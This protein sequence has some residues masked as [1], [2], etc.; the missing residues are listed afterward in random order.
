MKQKLELL[1]NISIVVLCLTVSGILIEKHFFSYP[2]PTPPPATAKGEILDLPADLSPGDAE[3]VVVAAVSPA[4]G[5]C[6][7]SMP[8][9]RALAERTR[10]TDSSVRFVAAVGDP[11]Q[12]E[13]ERALLEESGV[14]VDSIVV[15]DF[16]ALGIPGTPMLIAADRRGEVVGAWLGKLAEEQQQEVLETL[17]PMTEG[18]ASM[19]T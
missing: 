13:A 16:E 3:L 6:S 10:A 17:L 2:T 8:F 7:Q 15:T 14:D 18:P 11:S 5:F 9:Y 12:V 1:T 19:G 4:C